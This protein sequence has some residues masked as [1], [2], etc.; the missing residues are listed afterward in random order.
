MK[1]AS[2]T[3][4][5]VVSVNRNVIRLLEDQQLGALE[6]EYTSQKETRAI[7]IVLTG[8][9]VIGLVIMLLFSHFSSGALLRVPAYLIALAFLIGFIILWRGGIEIYLCTEGLLYI[10]RGKSKSIHWSSISEVQ[11]AEM[12]R[13]NYGS[14]TAVRILTKDSSYPFI[15]FPVFG[16]VP[17]ALRARGVRHGF[18]VV[19]MS[20]ERVTEV[21]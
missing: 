13:P 17:N 3:E 10:Q 14:S 6:E 11:V 20:N 8:L 9:V 2:V 1:Y 18:R 21:Y 16:C 5:E 15:S 19:S 4:E 12:V 7:C